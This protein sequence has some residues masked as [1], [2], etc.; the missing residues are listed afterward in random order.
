MKKADKPGLMYNGTRH[1][2]PYRHFGAWGVVP[3]ALQNTSLGREANSRLY[4]LRDFS[5]VWIKHGLSELSADV[6][7]MN[8]TSTQKDWNGVRFDPSSP[9]VY[10]GQMTFTPVLSGCSM[11]LPQ[12]F[13]GLILPCLSDATRCDIMRQ[14]M[15]QRMLR[16]VDAFSAY[17]HVPGKPNTEAINA[18]SSGVK[19]RL[20]KLDFDADKLAAFLD[21]WICQPGLTLFACFQALASSLELNGFLDSTDVQLVKAWFTSIKKLGVAEPPRVATRW[22]GVRKISEVPVVLEHRSEIERSL[23]AVSLQKNFVDPVKTLCAGKMPAQFASVAQWRQPL[24]TDIVLV[25]AFRYNK[26]LFKNLPYLET[27]HRPFF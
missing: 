17:H 1:F 10:V 5:R 20:H 23:P 7:L 8:E 16:E 26:F 19:H 14:Y 6:A 4:V 18:S 24:M 12:A 9:P 2:N 13:W 22:R 3:Y 15:T 11:Y 25:I 21:S 27:L